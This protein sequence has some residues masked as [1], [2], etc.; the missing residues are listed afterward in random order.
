MGLQIGYVYILTNKAIPKL[1]KIGMTTGDP[2]MRARRLSGTG[3]PGRWQVYA[4]VHVPNCGTVEHLVHRDLHKCRDTR[5]REFFR[6]TPDEALK[7]IYRRANENINDHPDWPDPIAVQDILDEQE[8]QQ[9]EEEQEWEEQ[10]RRFEIEARRHRAEREKLD[11]ERRRKE[12]SAKELE[13]RRKFVDASTRETL[14]KSLIGWGTVSACIFVG[15]LFQKNIYVM[16]FIVT[17]V[18]IC[19]IL[20][21]NGSK[22]DAINLREQ[23]N[24]PKIC[25][26]KVEKEATEDSDHILQKKQPSVTQ[27]NIRVLLVFGIV[28]I[29]G[30]LWAFSNTKTPT[31]QDSITPTSLE[32][33][34]TPT[35][36]YNETQ[37]SDQVRQREKEMLEGQRQADL[38]RQ[39]EE[40]RLLQEKK[41]KRKEAIKRHRKT[42]QREAARRQNK[43]AKPN[44]AIQSPNLNQQ[45]HLAI[46]K[47]KRVMSDE[48][49]RACGMEPPRAAPPNA[50]VTQ[51]GI[52][53]EVA[54]S[55]IKVWTHRDGVWTQH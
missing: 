48:D 28:T 55:G 36:F 12:E 53:H 17:V 34:T 27:E 41:Q 1:I 13:E 5:D 14:K 31:R 7:A 25:K 39:Y 22:R 9:K 18:A 16:W 52:R 10:Q 23:W 6:I 20:I 54:P 42:K 46:C 37:I 43:V 33:T 32:S 15:V 19:G 11:T 2:E 21:R 24:L 40:A 35:H 4:K 47:Y 8:L 38:A 3:T 30:L 51:D 29:I 44:T 45:P 26:D 49:Y 50:P